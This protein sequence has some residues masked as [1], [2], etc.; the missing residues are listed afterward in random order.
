MFD[1]SKSKELKGRH[2]GATFLVAGCAPSLAD[3]ELYPPSEVIS[4]G[5]NRILNHPHFVPNYVMLCDR[6]PY[7]LDHQMGVYH[8]FVGDVTYLASTTIWDPKIKCR[9]M[10]VLPQPDFPYYPWRVGTTGSPINLDSLE[11]PLCSFG[12]IAGP[13]IQAAAIM[14]AKRIGVVG[15]DF[16]APKVGPAHFYEEGKGEGQ[17]DNRAPWGKDTISLAPVRFEDRFTEL[18]RR[19]KGLGIEIVNLSPVKDTPFSSIFGNEDFE[20]WIN[21]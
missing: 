7:S 15:V 2:E 19:L 12:T 14:G 4:I 21:A 9:G 3:L 1:L 17:L 11:V 10:E 20:E 18:R 16:I 13:M 8:Q 6:L 5:P